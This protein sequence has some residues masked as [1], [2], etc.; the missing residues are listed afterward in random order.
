[1]NDAPQREEIVQAVQLLFEAG[2]MS[3]SGHGNGAPGCPT[4]G[5]C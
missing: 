4:G 3:H 5:C 1:M 2:V